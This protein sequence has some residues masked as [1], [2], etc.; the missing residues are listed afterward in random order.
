MKTNVATAAR[1][2]RILAGLVLL[3]LVFIP[4]GDV[5]WWGL[6]GLLPLA[7]GWGGRCAL[8]TPLGI[9][10]SHRAAHAEGRTPVGEPG[11]RNLIADL[12]GRWG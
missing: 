10:T 11:R 1:V 4:A 5:R 12:V 9:D 6:A 8:Y 2:I 3:G 7:T